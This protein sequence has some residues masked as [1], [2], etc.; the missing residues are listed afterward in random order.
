MK[1]EPVSEKNRANIQK[2]KAYLFL[3]DDYIHD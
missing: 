3:I 2:N 1:Q